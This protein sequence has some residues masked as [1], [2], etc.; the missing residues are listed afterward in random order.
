[1]TASDAARPEQ[2]PVLITVEGIAAYLA[3]HRAWWL[4]DVLEFYPGEELSTARASLHR[5]QQIS[6]WLTVTGIALIALALLIVALGA[7]PG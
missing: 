4:A 5:R 3:C 6:R 7:L 2:P 1:M